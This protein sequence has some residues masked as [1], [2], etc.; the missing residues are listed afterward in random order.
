MT[1]ADLY[2]ILGVAR[3]ASDDEIKKAY[4]ALARLHHPD[5]NPGDAE[6]EARFK[7]ISVAYETL[8]DP[9]RRRQYDMFGTAGMGAGGGTGPMGEAFGFGDLFEAFFGGDAFGGGRGPAAPPRGADV[10]AQI[11]LTL[12]EVA[13]GATK[14][15]EP[16]LPVTCGRCNGSGC[17]PGTH[18]SRCDVCGGSGELRQVRRS[19]LGQMVTA[20]PCHACGGLGSRIL[21][22]CGECGGEGRVMA[23]KRIDVEVP[24]GVDSGQRLRL[25]E[26]GP[27]AP[28]GGITGDLYVNVRV[29]P[30]PHLHRDGDDLLHV[31][32]IS[33]LQ[34][35]LGTR[36]Q[37]ETLDGA[38]EL[39]VPPG[40]QP[41]E[42][43]RLK[44]LGVR[45]LRGRGRGDLLV[46]TDVEVP[47]KLK[48]EDAELLRALAERRGEDVSPPDAKL[49]SRFRSAFQ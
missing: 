26:R 34:A 14:T 13:F 24:A 9:E 32:S 15:I 25:P 31:R 19:I 7:K 47:R 11:E 4:R 35:T 42:I 20:A 46:R 16:R 28:R 44:G 33:M 21:S 6:A 23:V 36:L 45:S 10:E 8:A 49:L 22:P 41:G 40:T 3:N 12:A 38:E 30:H 48:P 17:E 18:P 27:A 43:F 39:V 2:E 29:L 1:N 5:N 37:I